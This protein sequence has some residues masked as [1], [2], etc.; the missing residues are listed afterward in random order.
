MNKT[1]DAQESPRYKDALRDK[2]AVVRL[3]AC[4][5]AFAIP[6]TVAVILGGLLPFWG[7]DFVYGG[8]ATIAAIL[9]L[10]GPLNELGAVE[11]GDP[12][13]SD[14]GIP[15]REYFKPWFLRSRKRPD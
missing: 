6:V 13:P 4:L 12:P 2:R 5:I 3:L 14:P 9:L 10:V 11:L 15:T 8:A 1:H 7:S